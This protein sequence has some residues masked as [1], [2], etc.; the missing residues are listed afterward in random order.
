MNGMFGGATSA[1][2]NVSGWDTS[3]VIDMSYMFEKSGIKKINLSKWKLNE[4]VLKG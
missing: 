4:E 2:P 3:K 1:N